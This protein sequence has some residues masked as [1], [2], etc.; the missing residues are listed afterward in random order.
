MG[1]GRIKPP[2]EFW[3]GAAAGRVSDGFVVAS[4]GLPFE[5]MLNVLRLTDDFTAAD[6]ELRTGLAFAT[7]GGAVAEAEGRG[8]LRREE[9]GRWRVTEL[10]QRFLNDLQAL[11]LPV[12]QTLDGQS[13]VTSAA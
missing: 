7:V 1:S 5:Y 13:G 3:R 6:Y 10:G 2:R 12:G 8:L 11:F 4:A 9:A